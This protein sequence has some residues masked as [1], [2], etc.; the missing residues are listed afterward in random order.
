MKPRTILTGLAVFFVG[1]AVGLAA[2]MNMGTWKLNEAKSKLAAGGAKNT[3]VVYEAVGDMVKI[4][5]DGVNAAGK[6]VH[7]EWTGKYDGNDYAV[8]GDPT[9]DTRAYKTAGDRVLTFNAKKAGKVV[10]TGRVVLAADGKSRTVN[11]T[12]TD[13]NGK[14]VNAL[15]VYDK[16]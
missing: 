5:V 13:S 3:S 16:Q 10:T 9:S 12:T 1:A 15:S 11:A 2:D 14:K 6:P 7:H 4:T 8:T